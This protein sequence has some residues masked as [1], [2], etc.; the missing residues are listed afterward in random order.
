MSRILRNP[1][2]PNIPLATITYERLYQDQLNNAFRLYFNQLNNLSS[3]LVGST[4]EAYLQF[5]QGAFH[6]DGVTTLTAGL[7]NTSTTPITV[8]S[9]A[10]FLSAGG[11]LIGSELIKYTGKT[12][13]SF[14]GITRGAYGSTATSHAIGDYVSE[15]Q[16]VPSATAA[17]PISFTVTDSSTTVAVDP[18]D[19]TKLTFGVS[20]Y[21]NIQFSAQLLSYDNTVDN[22][23][24]WFRQNGVD[25]ANSAS[26]ISV[27]T[28]HGGNP[29]ASIL[30]LNLVL[31]I[32]EGDYIQLM[33]SSTTG[34]TVCAT[35]PPATLPTRP[36]SPSI[37]L[38]ATFVSSLYT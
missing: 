31:P 37:I 25:I 17:L 35:Y 9:T 32:I 13:T 4:G 27:P 36:A 33:L 29:G 24:M 16:P 15:A 7:T 5:P 34:N 38:T 23:C 22:V 18:T 6:Q 20:G 12:A 10:E 14:T 1:V 26:Y 2:P 30:A 3:A 8:A 19:L 28:I 11:L 21:Y